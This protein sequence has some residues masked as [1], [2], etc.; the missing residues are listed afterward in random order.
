[1]AL[2]VPYNDDEDDEHKCGLGDENKMG[3][4]KHPIDYAK[5]KTIVDNLGNLDQSLR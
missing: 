5:I 2:S 3:K 1:V 4:M